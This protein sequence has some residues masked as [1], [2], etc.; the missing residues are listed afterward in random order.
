M[1]KNVIDR[2]KKAHAYKK[3]GVIYIIVAS[4]FLIYELTRSSPRLIV[5]LLW[6]GVIALAIVVMTTLKDPRQ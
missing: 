1:F 6:G 3:R 5:L 2:Y 4:A